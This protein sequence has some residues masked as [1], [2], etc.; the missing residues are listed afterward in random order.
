VA[1][2]RTLIAGVGY[3]NLR[4]CSVGPV[5]AARLAGRDWPDGVEVDDYSFGAIDAIH[6]LRD[7]GYDRAVFFG[8]MDRGDEPGT[9]RRYRFAGGH[10]AAVVQER[11]AEAAQAVISLENTLIV[12]G[13]FGALPA[14]TLVFE[15]EPQDL[16]FGEGFSPAVKVAVEQLEEELHGIG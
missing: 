15:V 5:L 14:E 4:D 2:R 7:A 1:V 6:R 16:N 11:V 13:H 9:I 10:S 8:A 12:A 3:S